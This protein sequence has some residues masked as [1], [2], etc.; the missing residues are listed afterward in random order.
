MGNEMDFYE[1]G[2]RELCEHECDTHT[3][4][5]TRMLKGGWFGLTIPTIL[6]S[7]KLSVIA[8]S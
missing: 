5:R 1:V 2:T 4:T 3:L 8:G 7:N 6:S